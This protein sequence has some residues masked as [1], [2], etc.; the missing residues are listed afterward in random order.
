MV[1][2]ETKNK[3]DLQGIH[4][5]RARGFTPSKLSSI[6]LEQISPY[7]SAHQAFLN[8]LWCLRTSSSH[9]QA[10]LVTLS[11]A[12]P[13]ITVSTWIITCCLHFSFTPKNY[14]CL[15]Q[16]HMLPTTFLP[17]QTASKQAAPC[18]WPKQPD[19]DVHKMHTQ[20]LHTVQLHRSPQGTCVYSS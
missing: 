18:S 16:K 13:A 12:I 8:R 10:V 14:P 20:E 2:L 11:E 1:L 3:N 7:L 17:D 6:L 5:P 19:Q 4:Q 15:L 9:S